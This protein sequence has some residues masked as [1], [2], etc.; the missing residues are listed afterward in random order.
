MSY[1]FSSADID[2]KLVSA[3]HS[4]AQVR[5]AMPEVVVPLYIDNHCNGTCALCAMRSG[6]TNMQRRQGGK[7]EIANQLRIIREIE[8]INAVCF[9]SGELAPGP[10][11][12]QLLTTVAWGI[13]YAFDHGF[14]KVYFNIGSLSDKEQRVLTQQYDSSTPIVQVL[15]QETY[16]RHVYTQW[17]GSTYGGGKANFASRSETHNSWL[18]LAFSHVNL[19][20]LI[21]LKDPWEDVDAL[22]EH[23]QQLHERQAK[24]YLSL[25]RI[26]GIKSP[27]WLVSDDIYM[28]LVAHLAQACPWAKIV[29]TTRESVAMLQRLLP[30]IGVV[31]PGTSNLLAY[32]EQGPLPNRNDLS[33]FYVAEFRERPSSVLRQ[34]TNR[35]GGFLYFSPNDTP[36]T[37]LHT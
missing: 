11:R 37:T 7:A 31:S 36:A 27:P 22:I 32:T 18:G 13:G 35:H 14:E 5:S 28:A 9:L 29:L 12:E 30:V 19:G 17:F 21:G 1:H 4:I 2:A 34:L 33:Q 10:Q 6:N 3:A 25:P 15:F 16:D 26:R 23:A 24:V 8:K 20:V